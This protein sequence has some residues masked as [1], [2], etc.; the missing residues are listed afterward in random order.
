M[1]NMGYNYKWLGI[2]QSAQARL[3]HLHQDGM[4]DL[5]ENTERY[6]KCDL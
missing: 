6:C 3:K 5:D 2:I 1:E 4:G